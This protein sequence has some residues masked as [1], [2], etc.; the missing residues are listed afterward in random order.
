MWRYV[1]I[2]S[3]I[4]G[5]VVGCGGGGYDG[6]P[7][8]A[9]SGTVSL[10]GQPL[11]EGNIF[12]VGEDEKRQASGVIAN[13]EFSIPEETGPNVGTYQVRIVS[14]ASSSEGGEASTGEVGA[15]ETDELEGGSEQLIPAEYNER[16]TLTAEI[17]PGMEPLTFDLSS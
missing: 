7:R 12:F 10:N 8:V 16:T 3:P 11:P 5:L 4:L 13:G 6:P 14:Y 9:V 2:F 17:S 1:L 15:D